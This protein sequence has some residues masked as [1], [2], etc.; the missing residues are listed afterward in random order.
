MFLHKL[1]IENVRSLHHAEIDFSAASDETDEPGARRWTLFVGDNGTG[2]SSV[3]RCIALALVGGKELPELLGSPTAWVRRGSRTA[4]I[5]VVIRNAVGDEREISLVLRSS[6]T[7]A[8]TVS[9][10]AKGLKQLDD[11]LSHTKRS[12]FTAGYGASRRLGRTSKAAASKSGA[13]GARSVRAAA[14]RTLFDAEATLNPLEVWAR[15]LEKARGPKA[16]QVIGDALQPLLPG[17]S[18]AGFDK[19]NGQLLFTT[20]DGKLPLSQLSGGVQNVTAWCGDL[21]Y[22]LTRVFGDYENPLATRGLLLIDEIAL[23]LH[24]VWQRRLRTFIEDALPHFQ[25]VATTDSIVTAHQSKPGELHVL[26]RCGAEQKVSV[27]PF[28]G[29]PSKLY[30]HQLLGPA[31]QIDTFDSNAVTELKSTYVK[32]R[33]RKRRGKAANEQLAKIRSTLVDLPNRKELA[34]IA[35]ADLLAEVK[36][37]LTEVTGEAISVRASARSRGTGKASLKKRARKKSGGAAKRRKKGDGPGG[38]PS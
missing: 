7:A 19:K 12:Y 21:L 11:A 36:D 24:P 23:H 33:D 5:R 10:N 16:V 18:F 22:Q 35:D 28:P 14:M 30:L 29:D 8:R 9:R 34:T 1:E 15:K 4:R 38:S 13:G 6:D 20:P 17:M 25:I 27:D 2:K 26:S 3:L 37:A 32:L 31:F